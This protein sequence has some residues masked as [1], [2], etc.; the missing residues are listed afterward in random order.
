MKNFNSPVP[1][2]WSNR[3]V[4][5]TAQLAKY[6][7]CPVEH[8]RDNFRKNRDRFVANKHYENGCKWRA[9]SKEYGKWKTILADEQSVFGQKDASAV[10]L[11]IPLSCCQRKISRNNGTMT[12]ALQETQ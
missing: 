7:V 6:Y 3:R 2:E 10:E 12:R 1:V 8:I 4:L 11:G 5:T 9:L